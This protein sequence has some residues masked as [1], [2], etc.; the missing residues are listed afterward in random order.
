MQI[1]VSAALDMAFNNYLSLVS[2]VFSLRSAY[3]W[4]CAFV[5]NA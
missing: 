2:F 4:S 3:F 5:V 1:A